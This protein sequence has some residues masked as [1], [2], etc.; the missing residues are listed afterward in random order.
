MKIAVIVVGSHFSGKSRTIN[1]FLKPML[2][3]ARRARLFVRNDKHGC[4]LSQSFEESSVD[5][6]E[7]IGRYAHLDL[8]VLAA[9]PERESASRLLEIEAILFKH[10][11]DHSRVLLK[12]DQ[13]VSYYKA[14]AQRI[15]RNLDA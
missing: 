3:I 6:A 13:S 5:P 1:D 12:S 8:L 2:G 7:R 9:R 11:F 15:L 4:V 14:Q 10:R